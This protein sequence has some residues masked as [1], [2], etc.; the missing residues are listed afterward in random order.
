[1]S[2][3]RGAVR[4]AVAAAGFVLAACNA[5]AQSQPRSIFL[6]TPFVEGAP[7]ESRPDFAY[8]REALARRLQGTVV[9]AVLVGEEGQVL[10]HRIISAEPPLIFNA[11]VDTA[12]P[13]FR[14]ASANRDGRP[15]RYETHLTLVFHPP[16][17]P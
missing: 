16:P 17:T 7:V 10:R 8:P 4:T 5:F 1:M 13:G 15:A 2:P 3:L 6:G 9:V 11:T 12:I 14:F